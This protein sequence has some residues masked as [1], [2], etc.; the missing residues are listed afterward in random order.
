M[1]IL[2]LRSIYIITSRGLSDESLTIRRTKS[3]TTARS[4]LYVSRA[5]IA[6]L[7]NG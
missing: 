4:T 2:C 5:T 1:Y 7:K 6:V 3:L